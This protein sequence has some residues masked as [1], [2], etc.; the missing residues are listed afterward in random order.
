MRVGYNYVNRQF[1]ANTSQSSKMC[2][3]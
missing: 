2:E 1:W 3:A